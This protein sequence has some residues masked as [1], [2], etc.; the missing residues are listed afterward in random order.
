MKIPRD[1]NRPP[2]KPV[3]TSKWTKLSCASCSTHLA[4]ID[5]SGRLNIFLIAYNRKFQVYTIGGYSIILC[6]HCGEPNL[7][8]SGEWSASHPGEV[9]RI[10]TECKQAVLGPWLS[11]VEFEKTKQGG[12]EKHA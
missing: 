9:A 11:K 2:V 4:V 7:Y 3:D 8:L 1:A 5:E 6:R 10:A 12:L